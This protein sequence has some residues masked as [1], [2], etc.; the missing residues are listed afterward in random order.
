[1]EG[2]LPTW[3]P[4]LFFVDKPTSIG[5]IQLK[6][7]CGYL[8]SLLVTGSV[9]IIGNIRLSGDFTRCRTLLNP[10]LLGNTK[11]DLIEFCNFKESTVLKGLEKQ[12]LIGSAVAGFNHVRTITKASVKGLDARQ[13]DYNKGIFSQWRLVNN[14]VR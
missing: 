4:R 7:F 10:Q 5:P 3:L 9:E 6:Y 14:P 13:D 2:L 12:S 1:M 8:T 11:C